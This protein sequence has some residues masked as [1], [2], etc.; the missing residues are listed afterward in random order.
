[1]PRLVTPGNK[2]VLAVFSFMVSPMMLRNLCAVLAIAFL[3]IAPFAEAAAKT[4]SRKIIGLDR[5]VAIVNNEVITESEL[6][7]RVAS[8]R[9]RLQAKKIA[10]P[11]LEVLQRQVLE[12]M[13]LEQVQLQRAKTLGIRITDKQLET[14][15]DSVA[16]SNKLTR[17]QFMR[18]IKKTGLTIA[19]YKQELH[20]QLIIRR[21]I[22]REIRARI[23]ISDQEIL[24]Y[25]ETRKNILRRSESYRL[26]HIFIAIPEAATPAQINAAKAKAL[27]VHKLLTQG[28]DF[29]QVAIAYSQ[30][31][32]ALQG[33]DMG[34]RRPNQLP[35]LFLDTI[36][37]MQPGTFSP[38]LQSTNGYHILRLDETRGG[39]R[40]TLAPVTQTLVRHILI[41]PDQLLPPKEALK[42][43]LQLR[44]RII[45]G[46]DFATLARAHSADTISASRGGDLGWSNPGNLVPKFEKAMNGL[47]PNE[48]SQPVLT[49][50]GYH[51]IQVLG[52]RQQDVSELREKAEA[53]RSILARRTDE[54]YQRWLQQL[55]SEA[56]VKYIAK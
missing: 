47:K 25:L 24:E 6:R 50:Y 40:K 14:A 45:N 18:K 36:N 9:S 35:N 4:D 15:I 32:F 8:I 10:I 51:L 42:K 17:A 31:K 55:R 5:I 54:G 3:L 38:V 22:E 52:R 2:P 41:K 29:S 11:S 30:D 13:V 7:G 28:N 1:M 19:Q 20:R 23:R 12:R 27:Q 43:A 39:A 46:D 53:R 49:R 56:Y 48:I 44:E 26:S 21:L 16:K 34:W 37:K 33:G